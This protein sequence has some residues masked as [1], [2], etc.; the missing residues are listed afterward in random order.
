MDW[1]FDD[2]GGPQPEHEMPSPSLAR[3]IVTTLVA[4]AAL[5]GTVI[6]FAASFPVLGVLL[7][8]A[9]VILGWAA[10]VAWTDHRRLRAARA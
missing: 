3:P 5:L 8:V 9:A 2:S 7:V 4:L 6:A 10:G 1:S